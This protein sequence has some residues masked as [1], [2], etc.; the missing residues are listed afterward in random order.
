MN[1][2]LRVS[3]GKTRD[4][5]RV[6]EP[7]EAPEA[8]FEKMGFPGA[9]IVPDTANSAGQSTDIGTAELRVLTQNTL[10]QVGIRL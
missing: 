6:A 7:A 9:G 5:V 1:V 2:V 10:I 4:P 3:D 8:A